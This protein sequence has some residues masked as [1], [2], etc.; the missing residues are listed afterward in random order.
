MLP[1]GK[2]E[3]TEAISERKAT[4]MLTVWGLMAIYFSIYALVVWIERFHM[5]LLQSENMRIYWEVIK[6]NPF[7]EV[8]RQYIVLLYNTLAP[9]HIFQW[10]LFSLAPV[11]ALCFFLIGRSSLKKMPMHEA[12]KDGKLSVLGQFFRL[13]IQ[14]KTYTFILFVIGYAFFATTSFAN[15]MVD[16]SLGEAPTNLIDLFFPVASFI[17]AWLFIRPMFAYYVMTIGRK[18]C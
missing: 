8:G 7:S 18:D 15:C 12:A 13:F 16:L 6:I 10:L 11:L 17:L 14:D 2:R 9:L 4:E 5:P 1:Q 3:T